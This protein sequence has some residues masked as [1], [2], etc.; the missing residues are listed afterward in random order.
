MIKNLPTVIL[1]RQLVY[2]VPFKIF[3]SQLELSTH[4]V[5]LVT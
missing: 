1:V 5:L 2:A 3:F 4:T